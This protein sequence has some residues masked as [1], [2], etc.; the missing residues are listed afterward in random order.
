MNLRTFHLLALPV[1]ATGGVAAGSLGAAADQPALGCGT[2]VTTDVRLT[3]DLL[4]CPGSGLV[5]GADG[6]TIDLAGH[7]ID[8]AGSGAGVDN[9]SGYDDVRVTN[10]TVREFVFGVELFETAGGRIDRVTAQ[11]NAIGFAV[12]RSESIDVDRV[13]A[14]DN[15]SNG[16]DITFSAGVTVRRSTSADNELFGIVDRFSDESRYERNTVVGSGGPG[17]TVDSVTGAVVHRNRLADN[18]SEGM[19]VTFT[20]GAVVER[21]EAVGNAGDGILIDTPGNTLS[22]NRSTGNQGLGIAAP[23]GTIDGGRNVAN[24]N[25]AGGC[26]GV[27]CT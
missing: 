4:D 6:V 5:V 16:I 8:G 7:V 15:T 19:V 23:E 10:G 21:N 27:V 18:E 26:T 9:S 22:R 13:T 14:I 1:L 25:A 17:L 24:N 2:V 20:E 3:D 11:S 12:H